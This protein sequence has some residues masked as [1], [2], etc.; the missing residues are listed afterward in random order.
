[1]WLTGLVT[2]D[3]EKCI[4]KDLGFSARFGARKQETGSRELVGYWNSVWRKS[5]C[6]GGISDLACL[7][8]W[9]CRVVA[10]HGGRFDTC[11]KALKNQICE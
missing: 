6:V 11:Q 5:L 4:V 2:V 10:M 9:R 1:M 7:L 3:C 8:S